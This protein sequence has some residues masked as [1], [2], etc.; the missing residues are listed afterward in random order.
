MKASPN[1]YG[2][3]Q[4][5][6]GCKL[7]AYPDPK[8]GGVPW[9]IGWGSTGLGIER[10]VT[11]T[12]AQA[13]DRLTADVEKREAIANNALTVPVTQGQFDAFVDMIYNIGP[14]ARG[15]KDGIIMLKAGVY[16][17]FMRK[18]LARDYDGSRDEIIKWCSPGTNVEHGLTRRRTMDQALWDG[19]SAA[20]AIALGES[21]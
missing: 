1:C 21:V 19:K 18:L 16:S 2:V 7:K 6:E 14:G 15:A 5:I 20:E 10:G 8:T 9:T 4:H 17:T 12:Q 3:I 11:W 13:D